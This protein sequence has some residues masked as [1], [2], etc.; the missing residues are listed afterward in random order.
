MGNRTR[1]VLTSLASEIIVG[2]IDFLATNDT[3]MM[4]TGGNFT[5]SENINMST[6]GNFT[7]SE[8]DGLPPIRSMAV[9]KKI[10]FLMFMLCFGFGRTLIDVV[11]STVARRF[12]I[13]HLHGDYKCKGLNYG[14]YPRSIICPASEFVLTKIHHV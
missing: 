8:N 11:V 9:K 1:S 14:N 12:S 13:H 5:H 4:N 2:G 6:G 3:T 7:L 10:L